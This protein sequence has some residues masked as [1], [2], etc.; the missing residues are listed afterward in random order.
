M[1]RSF[2]ATFIACAI[3]SP[4]WALDYDQITGWTTGTGG[5]LKL[6]LR[7]VNRDNGY[8]VNDEGSYAF[9]TGV[10]SDDS[11]A[12]WNFEFSIDATQ[13]D[14]STYNFFLGID[15][16]TSSDV[17]YQSYLVDPLTYSFPVGN[18]IGNVGGR[19]IVQNSLNIA[20]FLP[21]Q[22]GS[23]EGTYDFRLFA[24]AKEEGNSPLPSS[25]GNIVAQNITPIADVNIQVIVSSGAP[26]PDAGGMLAI[27]G[28]SLAGLA[29]ISRR[30]V[31]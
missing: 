23:Q 25:G 24:L 31:A 6:G 4:A 2:V 7:A 12:L 11:K 13:F 9:P 14:L 5:V 21:F 26:V 29:G 19:Q 22:Y 3:T 10:A 27:L 15:I 17:N 28:L 20:S 30:R 16:D 8:T 1:K 18:T